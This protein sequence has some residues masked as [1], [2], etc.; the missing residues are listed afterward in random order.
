MVEKLQSGEIT[1]EELVKS[2]FDRIKEKDVDIKAYVSTLE[3]T[4]LAKA[5]DID[6]RRKKGGKSLSWVLKE[7]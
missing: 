7:P 2:Y 4:A 6:E 3:E 5:K 1:S